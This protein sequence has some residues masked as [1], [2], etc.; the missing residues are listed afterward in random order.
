MKTKVAIINDIKDD[1][2]YIR[3]A[4][5]VIEEGGIVAFPTETVY[6]L[7]A[8]GLD[9]KA[10]AGIY[11]AKGRPSD[12]PMILHISELSDLQDSLQVFFY[13]ILLSG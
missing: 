3:E 4:G 2:E 6:G 1:I 12:N 11:K 8:N 10:A 13:Q 5:T 7:G 9:A